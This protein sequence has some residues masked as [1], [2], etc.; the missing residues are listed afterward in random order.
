V[1]EDFEKE[2][3]IL[4]K[5]R[6]N[7]GKDGIKESLLSL[8]LLPSRMLR[9]DPLE[10]KILTCLSS[11]G[12]NDQ[13]NQDDGYWRPHPGQATWVRCAISDP[14]RANSQE[15]HFSRFAQQFFI[16]RSKG[17]DAFEKT[18]KAGIL[19]DFTQD[20]SSFI[21]IS[22]SLNC[23]KEGAGGKDDF[24]LPCGDHVTV[25]VRVL[26]PSSQAVGISLMDGITDWSIS[27]FTC[28]S[29]DRFQD[30]DITGYGVSHEWS[31]TETEHRD[32]E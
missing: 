27:K 9:E 24:D 1:H 20:N 15:R 29:A 32:H 16:R 13:D 21:R 7:P 23:P 28:F 4:G 14:D 17:V 8:G 18:S 3:K 31:K 6:E 12:N 5:E 30:H 22:N 10:H 25:P 2:H 19:Q 26:P 11:H